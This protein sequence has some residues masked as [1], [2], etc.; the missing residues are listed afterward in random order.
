MRVKHIVVVEVRLAVP[1]SGE[2]CRQCAAEWGD[3]HNGAVAQ[4]GSLLCREGDLKVRAKMSTVLQHELEVT[5]DELYRIVR[6]ESEEALGKARHGLA[7][8]DFR[9]RVQVPA[10]FPESEP[11]RERRR[12]GARRLRRPWV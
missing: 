9:H 11:T 4:A 3:Q 8:A 2:W 7:D 5:I 6:H 12:D 1:Q 10:L